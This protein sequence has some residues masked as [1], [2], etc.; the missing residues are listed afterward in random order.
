MLGMQLPRMRPWAGAFAAARWVLCLPCVAAFTLAASAAASA[1]AQS[2]TLHYQE[3]APY[4]TTQADG[5]VVGLTATPAAQALQQAGLAFTWALTPTRR[6]LALI[7]E[8]EGLHCGVGWFR[9]A[10]RKVLGKF[11]QALYR[12][13]PFGALVRNDSRL[14]SGLR[15]DEALALAGEVLLV[16]ECYS[17]GPA[18]DRWMAQR[19]PAPTKTR[20]DT[21][22]MARMLLAGRA[23]WMIVAPE[24]SLALR[25]EMGAAGADLRSVAFADMPAGE[26]RHLYCNRAVPDAW[27]AR[28]DQALAAAAR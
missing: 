26:T 28:I 15:G 12:D 20:V 3:R 21:V 8:G 25:Q 10:E 9:N 14:H 6:Q 4:S 17:Y 27:L 11:S 22:Q 1:V 18:L 7:Q 16:K 5:S 24:E 2:L 13:R 23:S 19:T